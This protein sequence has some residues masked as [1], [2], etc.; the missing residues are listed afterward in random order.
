MAKLR[1]WVAYRNVERPYTRF[2]KFRKKA[3]VKSRPGKK[4]IKYDMGDIRGGMDQFPV[5][6]RL[7]SKDLA[8]IRANA[9]EASRVVCLKRLE[10]KFGRVGFYF[11]IKIA[12]HQAIRE[13]ALAAGAGA[14]RLS[15][16]MKHSFGKIIGTAAHVEEGSDIFAIYLP[17]G[18]ENVARRILNDAGKKLPVRV[19]VVCETRLA[20]TLTVEQLAAK[21]KL[22]DKLRAQQKVQDDKAAEEK[23]AAAKPEEK[24]K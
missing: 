23:A 20:K 13:N 6:G 15:T 2:S 4:I 22:E 7:V 3:F 10:A 21:K 17:A 12:P 19:K 8:Q 9:L 18:Q 16:G 14:D 24:K 11:K 1:K 5:V